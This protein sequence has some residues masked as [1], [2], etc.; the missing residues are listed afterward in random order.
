MRPKRHKDIQRVLISESAIKRRVKALGER[1]SRDYVG[2]KVIVVSVLKGS[3]IFLA[4]LLRR[5][6]VPCSL[7]FMA[8]SSYAGVKSTGA[9]RMLMDLR[10]NPKGKNIILVEDIV[11]SG[12]TLAFLRESLLARDVASLKVCAL[13][14]KPDCHRVPVSLDYLGFSVPDEFVVGYGLDFTEQYR[15]LP[16]IGVLK[17]AVYRRKVYS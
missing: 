14:D 10:E 1:I 17:K 8:V 5:I 3:V 13:L 6:V 2:Q 16:Y 15:E 7:D 9:V 12:L 11:D 4:D